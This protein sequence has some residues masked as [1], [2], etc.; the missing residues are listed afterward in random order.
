M[1]RIVFFIVICLLLTGIYSYPIGKLEKDTN[2]N[3][4]IVEFV[5]T[6]NN[7]T[8]NQLINI[9]YPQI[10]GVGDSDIERSINNQLKAAALSVLNEF[11]TLEDMNINV[12]YSLDNSSRV[13]SVHFIRKSFHSA[14][15]YPLVRI[16]ALSF[17][18]DSGKRIMLKDVINIDENFGEIFFCKFKLQENYESLD[19]KDVINRYVSKII[20]IEKFN[21]CGEDLNSDCQSYVT[22]GALFIS[23]A[24]PHSLGSY[25]LY[26][27][28]FSDI[29]D[30]LRL[31]IY[32][33]INE[34]IL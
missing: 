21:L 32:K 11:T 2:A 27:A 10:V 1:K 18:I 17:E 20:S 14:Q 12:T 6:E 28:E 24:V 30:I 9:K 3:Y 29:K 34:Q 5:Y 25:A 8:L 31:N 4:K 22:D 7:E 33:S 13:L 26:E 15:A 19:D 23:I 16:I